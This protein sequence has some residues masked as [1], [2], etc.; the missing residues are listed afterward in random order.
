MSIIYPQD[1]RKVGVPITIND[2]DDILRQ[3]ISGIDCCNLSFSGGVDSSLLLY[4]LL[5]VKGQAQTFTIAN[6]I[7]HADLEY[8]EKSV[9]YFEQIYGRCID[10]HTFVRPNVDGDELVKLFYG[11]LKALIDEIIAGDCLDEL[12]CGYYAHQ[13]LKE[14]TYQEYLGHLQS[15]HLEPLNTNSGEVKVY[16]PY[17]SEKITNLFYRIPL[18]SKVSLNCRKRVI[19]ELAEGKVAPEVIARKKYGFATTKVV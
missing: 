18:Y 3:V 6:D 15:K 19:M 11:I 13:D 7:N 4:Y 12:C 10:N 8:A 5:E 14:E 1:W 9:S 2:I 16:L 17:A